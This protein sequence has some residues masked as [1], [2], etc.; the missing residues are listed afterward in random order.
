MTRKQK[1]QRKHRRIQ[2]CRTLYSIRAAVV[3]GSRAK[4]QRFSYAMLYGPAY[5]INQ[6]YTP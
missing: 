5:W 6:G 3:N 1:R 4:H 2:L